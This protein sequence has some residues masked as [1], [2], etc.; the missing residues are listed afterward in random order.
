M[1]HPLRATAAGRQVYSVPLIVFMDDVS[2][3]RS[4]QWNK[5]YSVYMS[6]GTIPRE[7]LQK[8]FHVRYVTTSS[9]AEPLELMQGVKESFKKHFSEPIVA[10]DAIT[11]EEVLLRPW[12]LFWPGDN[13]MQAE[14]C[15]SAGLNAS[16]FCRTCEVGGSQ[17]YC[18]SDKGFAELIVPGIIRDPDKTRAAIQ[19][20]LS[21]SLEPRSGNKLR[22]SAVDSGVKDS[23][24]QVV[25]EKLLKMG[26]S[27]RSDP[28]KTPQD[29]Q[30]I[31]RNELKVAQRAGC[32]N[33][34]LKME[35]VNIHLDTPT[36]ILHTIL[37]GVVKY[38][39]GQT[40]YILDKNKKFE[41]MRSRLHTIDQRGLNIPTIP[42][43]Y[44]CDYKGALI[45]KHFKALAQ[46]LVF[47][48]YDLVDDQN[49]I[50]AWIL[51]SRLT[52][53]LW[54]TEIDNVEVYLVELRQ[55]IA[56][57][58]YVTAICS[59]SII[60]SKPKFH[61][62]VHLPLYIERFGPAL[63]FS[64]ERF[65]SFN[66]IFRGASVFSN[67][68]SP[69]RD[70]GLSFAGLD[71]AKH[72]ATGGYWRD[73]QTN[74]WRTA[75]PKLQELIRS[76]PVFAGLLG[77][78]FS[79]EPV[80][81]NIYFYPQER[82][83]TGSRMHID[84]SETWDHVMARLAIEMANPSTAT[85]EFM[86][87]SVKGIVSQSGDIIEQGDSVIYNVSENPTSLEHP[88]YLFA[89]VVELLCCTNPADPSDITY[90]A[91]LQKFSLDSTRHHILQMPQLVLDTELCLCEPLKLICRVNV[92]HD[93]SRGQCQLSHKV[94]IRQER[95]LTER[96]RL[97]VRHS[98]DS[99]Y[100]LNVQALHN[101]KYIKE[102]LPTELRGVLVQFGDR[103]AILKQGAENVRTRKAQK[104]ANRQATKAAKDA[105]ARTL[106]TSMAREP[107]SR[108]AHIYEDTQ[109]A[110]TST[111]GAASAAASI[112]EQQS[113]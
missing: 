108:G 43:S 55:V 11:K 20:Q 38:F 5:H 83:M 86:Y 95:E 79:E 52:V 31:L 72:L 33:P 59:P 48:I 23:L 40:V 97:A 14:H 1:P 24:A 61:F 46:V 51:T 104:D 90:F 17:E 56:D 42:V 105:F 13:P 44:I 67:R 28:S 34:L 89:R 93:C 100:I 36:E 37:L 88:Q 50:N 9:H 107:E 10:F 98:D 106:E 2:G 99:H 112:P 87:A 94:P 63:L 8:E 85:D 82:S 27:L 22:S 78:D 71:R 30:D 18:S 6:N 32:E 64:T 96:C 76:H 109:G 74:D 77:L 75:S 4:T 103:S 47:V 35:G 60:L 80:P 19:T 29:I 65:E 26:K 58:L 7:E 81:G 73:T 102:S 62:L 113:L 101:S 68:Q 92:Q 54:Q 110:G 49:L 15:S 57:L 53:L 45:G 91:I 66:G 70:I 16:R 25:I 111:Q 3:A 41:I 39:W 12:P 69:S 21:L 84:R